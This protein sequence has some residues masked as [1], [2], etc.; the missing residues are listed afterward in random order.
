[1]TRVKVPASAWML[2]R[3]VWR[4]TLW[5]AVHLHFTKRESL[6][7]SRDNDVHKT[8]SHAA[9]FTVERGGFPCLDM[10]DE[11]TPENREQR[12]TYSQ[13]GLRR[14]ARLRGVTTLLPGPGVVGPAVLQRVPY[15]DL[16]P[17]QSLGAAVSS[18][19]D[20]DG[21]DD[22]GPPQVHLPPGVGRLP[23]SVATLAIVVKGVAP[24]IDGL[25][26]VGETARRRL[27]GHTL[28]RH[29]GKR[30]L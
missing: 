14:R 21:R 27:R 22:V 23:G 12:G 3:R 2:R 20:L 28:Q 16:G 8:T 6:V 13:C 7:G 17:V 11:S 30:V 9:P 15:S 29:V 10:G 19:G 5:H 26:R 24:P 18:V 1:M 4:F 25:G